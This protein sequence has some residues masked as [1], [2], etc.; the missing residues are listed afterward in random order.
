MIHKNQE[1]YFLNRSKPTILLV[2]D[3]SGM[4]NMFK[5]IDDIIE[6]QQKWDL[7]EKFPGTTMKNRIAM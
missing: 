5:K 6:C 7:K 3:L 1:K 2:L 4:I